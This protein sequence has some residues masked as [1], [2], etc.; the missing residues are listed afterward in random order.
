MMKRPEGWIFEVVSNGTQSAKDNAAATYVVDGVVV[1]V[2]RGDDL[3]DDLLLELF[4]EL[5]CGNLRSVLSRNDNGVHA[6]G[7][8][9]TV[10]VL[11]LDGDLSL[12]VGSQPGEG[13]I[14]AGSRHGSVELVGEEKCEGEELRGLVG[15]V[16]EHDTLVTG[17]ELLEGLLVVKTLSDIRRLLLNGDEQVEGLVVE[18]LGGVIVTDVLDG[19]TDDLLVVESGLGGDLT[20]DHDHTSLGG[21]LA[22]NLGEGILS[23]TGIEDGIGDLI[24]DLVGVTLTDGLGLSW[25]SPVSYGEQV[26][27]QSIQ[28]WRN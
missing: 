12:G 22:S 14:A 24:S 2:L 3:L 4:A 11:V 10:V 13:A 21:S 28:V 19:V 18:T 8:D 7:D 27:G 5:L 16:A 1:E 9:G 6:L 25:A 26:D 23:Q 15:G 17:T 20:E